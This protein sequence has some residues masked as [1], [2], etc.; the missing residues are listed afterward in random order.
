MFF[1]LFCQ[2]ILQA[3]SSEDEETEKRLIIASKVFGII[4]HLI[5]GLEFVIIIIV[6]TILS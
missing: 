3:Q 2:L 6:A 1:N 4:V 5:V